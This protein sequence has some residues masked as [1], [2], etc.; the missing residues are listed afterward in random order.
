M[1]NTGGIMMSADLS[2]QQTTEEAL[3]LPDGEYAM[4]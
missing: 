1:C 3:P 4:I 2:Y